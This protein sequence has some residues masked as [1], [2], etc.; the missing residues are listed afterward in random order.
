MT[1]GFDLDGTLDNPNIL[2]LC[3]TLLTAGSDV[4]IITGLFAESGW[5][6]AQAKCRKLDRLGIPFTQNNTV[7]TAGVA[8]VWML[9]A[10]DESKSLDYRLRDLGLRK[11]ELCERLGISLFVEDSELYCELIPKFSGG[12][13]I[14]QVK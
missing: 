8:R 10:V 3:R 11:G 2:K 12:T 5:Q 9:T 4:H 13:T 7:G 6:D 1:I 14:L